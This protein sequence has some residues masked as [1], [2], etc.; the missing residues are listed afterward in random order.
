MLHAGS[1]RANG[2]TLMEILVAMTI[3]GIALGV[4]FGALRLGIRSWEKGNQ[5]AEASQRQR[6]ALDLIS[7][8]IK[9][10]F[11]AELS[12]AVVFVGG[13]D[14][15]RLFTTTKGINPNYNIAGPRPVSYYVKEEEGLYLKEGYP[16][17]T[18]AEDA[19]QQG[20]ELLLD[21][22]V[23]SVRFRYYGGDAQGESPWAEVWD[24]KEKKKLPVAVEITVSY[25]GANGERA[26]VV[27][28]TYVNVQ[29]KIVSTRAAS[30]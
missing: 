12:E 25:G 8:D 3:L 23:T 19:F 1:K 24:S 9:S 11:F 26:V 22:E 30:K 16:W 21:P 6:I 7:Q 17:A 14:E 15:L 5:S 2:F 20:E 29:S 4:I 10:A 27:V 28:P 18:T 13:E